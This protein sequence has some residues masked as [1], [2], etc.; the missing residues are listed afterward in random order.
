MIWV[1]RVFADVASAFSAVSCFNDSVNFGRE[2]KSLTSSGREFQI[3]GP[4]VLEVFF[5]ERYSF[6]PIK[7]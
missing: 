7:D 6:C 2:V 3:L 5:T 4:N 1:T